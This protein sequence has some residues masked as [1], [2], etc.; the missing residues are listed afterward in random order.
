MTEVFDNI[1]T[2]MAITIMSLPNAT[3][4]DEIIDAATRSVL[5][6]LLNLPEDII[7][8]GMNACI[9]DGV[10]FVI[11]KDVTIPFYAVIH[12]IL[13]DEENGN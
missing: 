12:A 9:D 4:D 11:Q 1:T 5:T 6:A 13:G 7:A 3:L 2:D 8:A 10:Q